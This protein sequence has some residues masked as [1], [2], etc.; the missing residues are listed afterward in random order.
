MPA[1]VRPRSKLSARLE[2]PLV[3]IPGVCL[4]RGDDGAPCLA[5]FVACARCAVPAAA[6]SV[7]AR[8]FGCGR[9]ICE[10]CDVAE[11]VTTAT[12]FLYP[13]DTV[14]HPHSFRRPLWLVVEA[15]APTKRDA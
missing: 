9:V 13:G 10:R 2:G 12:F 11:D 8:C 15:S 7:C 1:L 14:P 4:E 6:C 3:D 5:P